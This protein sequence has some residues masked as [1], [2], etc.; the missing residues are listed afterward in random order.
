MSLK[1]SPWI[2]QLPSRAPFSS[3]E[4]SFDADVVV[5]GAGIAGVSTA[6]F[7]L[8]QTSRSVVVLEASM[9]AHG[10]TGHNAGQ[11]VRYF[12]RSFADMIEEFGADAVAEGQRLVDDAFLDLER[13]AHDEQ[14]SVR[15]SV[16]TGYAGLQDRATIERM[17][18]DI[19]VQKRLGLE[20]EELLLAKGVASLRGLPRE[21]HDLATWLPK[22]D[23][24]S[25]LGTTN[26]AYIGALAGKKGCLNSA[27]FTEDLFHILLKKYPQRLKI[28]EQSPVS[29][30]S[31]HSRRIELEVGKKKIRAR[32]V[33]LCTN[34]FEHFSLQDGNGDVLNR[35]FHRTVRGS[36]GYM[37]GYLEERSASP[38]IVSFLPPYKES[39]NVQETDPYMYVT[40]RP[41]EYSPGAHAN[42]VCVGGPE[43]ILDNTASYKREH[44]YPVAASR[45]I[46]SF[47]QETWRRSGRRKGFDFLWH[48][49]MGYTPNGVRLV[50]PDIEH[51]HLWYNLG[52]NGVGILTSVMGGKRIA[53]QM[54]G[55]HLAPSMFDVVH[56]RG[57]QKL[58]IGQRIFVYTLFVFGLV[59]GL[60]LGGF[61]SISLFFR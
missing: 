57:L 48:G 32:D 13:I 37:A 45:Q 10:A 42:L 15:L 1:R 38:A 4:K 26:S 28:F 43:R 30:V 23:L 41:Y 40:R 56:E 17:A 29:R 20:T 5:V 54:R 18:S 8:T 55:D 14:L 9:I 59:L 27:L 50:G 60:G 58:H 61:L 34:G 47:L 3:F 49:L 2:H 7:L 16:V 51:P 25:L 53:L 21:I 12:E 39:S 36:I 11:A 24:L 35:W 19:L 6:Y 46:S 52:C 33:V 31:I 22:K 44:A